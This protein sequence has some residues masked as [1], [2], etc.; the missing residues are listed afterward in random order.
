MFMIYHKFCLF[1]IT[2]VYTGS[3]TQLT[4]KSVALSRGI[5]ASIRMC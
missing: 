2:G 4:I 1:I 3:P 5:L